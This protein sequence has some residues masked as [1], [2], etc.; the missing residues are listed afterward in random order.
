MGRRSCREGL[1]PSSA[2][3][4]VAADL[5]PILALGMPPMLTVISSALVSFESIGSRPV[6]GLDLALKC[7]VRFRSSGAGPP[8]FVAGEPAGGEAAAKPTK[9]AHPEAFGSE[10]RAKDESRTAKTTRGNGG[11]ARPAAGEYIDS[12][13]LDMIRFVAARLLDS[14]SLQNST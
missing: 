14:P 4:S 10:G 1:T 3:G 8:G 13:R 7:S 2:F 12:I 5:T 9:A 6:V 11:D